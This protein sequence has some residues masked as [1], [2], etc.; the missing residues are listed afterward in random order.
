MWRSED[1]GTTW[2]QINDGL[3]TFLNV[4]ALA[5]DST[6]PVNLYAGTDGGGVFQSTDSGDTWSAI[7]GSIANAN[8]LS[9]ALDPDTSTTLY[10]GTAG[11]G[12]YKITGV[13]GSSS[14]EGGGGG[15]GCFIGSAMYGSP[16][17]RQGP[18]DHLVAAILIGFISILIMIIAFYFISRRLQL[19]GVT[20]AAARVKRRFSHGMPILRRKWHRSYRLP[21]NER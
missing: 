18:L 5:I 8:V 3:G 6:S 20:F 16:L 7:G 21:T 2:T 13:G 17:S 19:R 4:Q 11:E 10:A 9:L 15:G 12:L 1:S 14:T